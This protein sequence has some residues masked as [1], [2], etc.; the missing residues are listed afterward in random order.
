MV[1]PGVDIKM[2]PVSWLMRSFTSTYR[3]PL[4]GSPGA[5]FL[6]PLTV[7]LTDVT[8]FPSGP[9]ISSGFGPE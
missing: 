1:P 4:S 6:T 2:L 7:M 9:M 5:G 8:T 3:G